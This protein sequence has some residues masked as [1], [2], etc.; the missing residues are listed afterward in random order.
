[1]NHNSLK[2]M[3]IPVWD[4]KYAKS[5]WH[6]V[7]YQKARKLFL[8]LSQLSQMDKNVYMKSSAGQGWDSLIMTEN[9]DCIN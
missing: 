8:K 1:M 6:T 3:L 2:K 4:D 7:L 9:N 5:I